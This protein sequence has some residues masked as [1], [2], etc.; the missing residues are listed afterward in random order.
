MWEEGLGRQRGVGSEDRDFD[1]ESALDALG[2]LH[3]QCRYHHHHHADLLRCVCVGGG[4]GGGG[5]AATGRKVGG[6]GEGRG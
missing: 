1:Y 6:G 2:G 3:T 5:G 4:V